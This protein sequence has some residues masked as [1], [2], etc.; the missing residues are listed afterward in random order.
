MSGT[1][2]VYEGYAAHFDGKHF[3]LAAFPLRYIGNHGNNPMSKLIHVINPSAECCA[4]AGS[5]RINDKTY[6]TICTKEE[7]KCNEKHP[8]IRD[9]KLFKELKE[10]HLEV[11]VMSVLKKENLTQ[12]IWD[13]VMNKFQPVNSWDAYFKKVGLEIDTHKVGS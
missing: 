13:M 6:Q 11:I 2:E 7:T 10:T 1:N 8:T 4:W 9:E 12:N 5:I 3:N